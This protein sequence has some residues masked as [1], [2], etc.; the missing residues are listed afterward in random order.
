MLLNTKTKT[1]N[2]INKINTINLNDKELNKKATGK[3]KHSPVSIN[4]WKNVVYSYNK[5]D[6][7]NIPL[8]TKIIDK[9][10]QNYFNLM[11]I[12]GVENNNNIRRTIHKNSKKMKRSLNKVLLSKSEIKHTNN[13]S[14]IN[15]Y[16]LN[17]EK[18]TLK[19]K[20]FRLNLETKISS[21]YKLYNNTRN[22][23]L[24]NFNEKVKS[25]NLL[26]K[27]II[28]QEIL[29]KKMLSNK[30]NFL[31]TISKLRNNKR[32]IKLYKIKKYNSKKLF[33]YKD[34]LIL[35]ILNKKHFV[36]N[37]FFFSFL[38]WALLLFRFN[39]VINKSNKYNMFFVT[40][41]KADKVDLLKIRMT[42]DNFIKH[43]ESVN[44]LL[45]SLLI[46]SMDRST[47]NRSII[48]LFK[49]FK[50]K[51]YSKY[52]KLRLKK[53]I[54]A[55][56]KLNLLNINNLKFNQLVPKLK[57][58]LSN[59]LNNKIELNIINLKY[60]YMNTDMF[61]QAIATKLK[62][63]TSRLLLILKRSLRLIN[64]PKHINILE[65]RTYDNKVNF[66]K[67]YSA[68]DRYKNF[69]IDSFKSIEEN[70][71]NSDLL[72]TVIS[73]IF[74]KA[75][76]RKNLSFKFDAKRIFNNNILNTI[77]HKWTKGVRLEVKGR[78]TKRYTASRAVFKYV[79]LGNLRDNSNELSKSF[80][81]RGDN[82]SNL[83]YSFT[84]SKKRIG[85]FG[86]KGW[87]ST[88]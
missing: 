15:I 5:H 2:Q 7:K 19:N 51:Y 70:S 84:P 32:K 22:K 55:L 75:N 10:L 48:S 17:N 74:Y 83:S 65:N 54:T 44:S 31:S 56:I 73:N 66:I 64:M 76:I 60:L 58:L 52:V 87:I 71:G 69:K 12:Y 29:R 59:I 16:T 82:R 8:K 35:H 68:T 47:R 20:L 40:V 41:K 62:T 11:F 13:K 25:S 45:L 27:N 81:I 67:N 9:V 33:Y 34:K 23:Y 14:I 26:N 30:R 63:K 42:K 36:R 46:K 72:N 28:V 78:L 49:F 53:E 37:I 50:E 79:Y 6:I 21:L 86:V 88:K 57:V 1:L 61:T 24:N 77:K 80:M 43:I 3:V 18:K 39:V 38:K 4:E 85:S